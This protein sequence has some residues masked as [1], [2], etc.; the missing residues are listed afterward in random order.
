MVTRET[1]TF[2]DVEL[3]CG[4]SAWAHGCFAVEAA[5]ELLIDHRYWLTRPDFRRE[6]V[7][8]VEDESRSTGVS[9]MAVIDWD[10]VTPFLQAAPCSR[11]ERSIL[12]VAASLAG[13]TTDVSL[14]TMTTGLDDHNKALLID[15]L[16]H[17]F[18]WHQPESTHGL[19]P[20]QPCRL[21]QAV[22]SSVSGA[23]R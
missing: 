16:C 19:V 4:L 14:F 15:A 17:R 10:W 5:V 3:A 8:V 20:S 7:D 2:T 18:G 11:S 23:L 21:L 22:P 13:G 9:R 1:T 12:L 6:L